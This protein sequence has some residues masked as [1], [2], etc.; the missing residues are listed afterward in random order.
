MNACVHF[1]ATHLQDATINSLPHACKPCSC[2]NFAI[3][4]LLPFRPCCQELPLE[5]L[6]RFL[7]NQACGSCSALCHILNGCPGDPDRTDVRVEDMTWTIRCDDAYTVTAARLN[8]D[9]AA[10]FG[11]V[12]RES[13]KC[14]VQTLI[15]TSVILLRA[16]A[17]RC[18][19]YVPCLW[20]HARSRA[21]PSTQASY[22]P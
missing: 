13:D 2:C 19:S 21:L 17:E 16:A 4:L 14:V 22:P 9:T 5:L 1:P 18:M 11:Y 6:V 3:Q 12:V 15:L 10:S 7:N 8:D 20:L